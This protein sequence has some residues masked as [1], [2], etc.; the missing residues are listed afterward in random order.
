M[1][2]FGI[3]DPEKYRVDDFDD[4]WEN[5]RGHGNIL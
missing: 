2:M 4:F 1:R 5:E 3:I